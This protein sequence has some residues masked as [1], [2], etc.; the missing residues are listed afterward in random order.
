[1]VSVIMLRAKAEARKKRNFLAF[2]LKVAKED[3]V[4]FSYKL[5]LSCL[6]RKRGGREGV[7]ALQNKAME[8]LLL[9][10]EIMCTFYG[11]KCIQGKGGRVFW[12]FSLVQMHW[13]VSTSPADGSS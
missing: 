2:I 8:K 3:F 7:P 4:S 9:A 10:H 13:I 11:S 6:Q 5:N 1:M 12:A